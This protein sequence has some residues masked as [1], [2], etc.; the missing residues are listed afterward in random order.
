MSYR[1]ATTTKFEPPEAKRHRLPATSVIQ[2]AVGGN[3]ELVEAA[4]EE[5]EESGS[6]QDMHAMDSG[7]DGAPAISM[8]NELLPEPA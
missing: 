4:G 6:V 3:A 2:E 5:D 7:N 8:R 1:N